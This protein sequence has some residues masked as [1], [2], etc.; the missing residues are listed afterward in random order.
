[1]SESENKPQEHEHDPSPPETPESAT[2]ES[3]TPVSV[4]P[5]SAIPPEAPPGSK[6]EE[7]D[8]AGKALSDALRISFGILKIVMIAVLG[9]FVW[10]GVY[11]VEANEQA[12][13]LRFGK[14]KGVGREAI[15]KTG[16]HWKWPAPIE[17][18]IKVPAETFEHNLRVNQFWHNKDELDTVYPSVPLRIGVDGYCVTASTSVAETLPMEAAA[19]AE[20]PISSQ[21]RAV[22]DYNLVHTD[23]RL[24]YK[25]VEP[26]KFVERLWDGLEGTPNRRDGWFGVEYFLKSIVSDAVVVTSAGWD[27]ERILWY[28]TTGYRE[29][30]L[31]QVVARLEQL[32]VG[33][34]VAGLDLLDKAPPLQVKEVFDSVIG[35]RS[36]SAEFVNRAL[37]DASVTLSKAQAEADNI[38]A[39]AR[40]Y[41]KTVVASAQADTNYFQDVWTGIEQTVNR[42]VPEETADYEQKRREKFQE[43]LDITVDQLYQEMLREV[44]GKAKEVFLASTSEE[45]EEEMR[46]YMSRDTN[47]KRPAEAA[48]DKQQEIR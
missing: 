25:V 44:M 20:I 40:A 46:I 14:V 2:P 34:E 4:T 41:Q 38:L 30:V 3:K 19:E 23:W 29:A 7:L 21:E 17:E 24:R 45:I 47:I 36:E 43:L 1:M 37:G 5:G 9:L 16:L 42:E 10:S 28:D 6:T 22:T 18:I 26:I 11:K 39:Q 13:E 48:P 33:L 8:P 15:V 32:D 35:V 27:I 31:E 12:L